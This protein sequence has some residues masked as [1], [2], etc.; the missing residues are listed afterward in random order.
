MLDIACIRKDPREVE[1]LLQRRGFTICFSELLEWDAKRRSLSAAGD[2]LKAKRNQLSAQVPTMKKAGEDTSSL[3]EE[4]RQIGEEIKAI[5]ADVTEL[6]GCIHT[7]LASLPNVTDP[8]VQP[9]GK[10]NNQV[11]RTWGEIPQFDF[12]IKNHVDLA[13]SLHLIDY[14]RGAKLGG[15]GKWVYTGDGALL[16]WALLNYFIEAHRKDGYQFMLL[17]HLLNYDAGYCSGQFPKFEGDVFWVGEREGRRDQFLLPTAETALVSLHKGEILSEEEL[18]KKYFAYTPCYRS[19]AGSYRAEE[20][21]MIRGNQF[22][23]VEMVHIVPSEQSAAAFEELVRKASALVEGLG[24]HH[25]IVKLAAG[26]CSASMAR[27]YDIEVWI[28]SMGIYKEVSSVSNSNDYQARRGN[29]RVKRKETGKNEF[30]HILNGSGL[31]TSRIFPTILEQN[32]QPDGSVK[33]PDVL[34]KWMNKEYI[35][36]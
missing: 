2:T 9:G 18:P 33:V 24:L 4:V 27:T 14:T 1:A 20:R 22:N 8:D 6:E 15:S 7:F 23:K 29:I 10:E 31:A 32:Q 30:V 35:K 25:Q 26:D 12:P 34:V 11:L 13:E 17:P 21:G 16:E 36:P 28:P 5:D 3:F 19:E